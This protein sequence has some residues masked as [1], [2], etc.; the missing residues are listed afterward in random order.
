MAKLT[1]DNRIIRVLPNS[2][3]QIKKKDLLKLVELS[4]T[5]DT[6]IEVKMNFFL[7]L[8]K[9]HRIS[10]F[11]DSRFI[12]LETHKKEQFSVTHSQL[13][14]MIMPLNFLFKEEGKTVMINSR[15]R[16]QLIPFFYL[17]QIQYCGPDD[18]L[19]NISFAEWIECE[20]HYI[21]YA[22]SKNMAELNSLIA[23]IY[24]PM[25][26]LKSRSEDDIRIPFH[27][28]SIFPRAIILNHLDA[29]TKYAILLFY[30]GS[31]YFIIQSFP[32]V[33]SDTVE[34]E[35]NKFGMANVIEALTNDDP[36]KFDLVEQTGLFKILLSLENRM[37]RADKLKSKTS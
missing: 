29:P 18:G 7:Y 24:R 9:L 36:T 14:D 11:E 19:T 32:H 5:N 21:N 27:E 3:E 15:L 13:I 33:Y 28:K 20:K 35:E 2:W 37:K 25:A 12:K 4:L 31:R 23:A 30:E 22:K 10:P 26:D 17:H 16:K 8:T 1:I 34:K 6:S